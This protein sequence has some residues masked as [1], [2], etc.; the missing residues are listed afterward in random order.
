MPKKKDL[1]INKLVDDNDHALESVVEGKR[2]T[3]PREDKSLEDFKF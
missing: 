2:F 3:E 1:T